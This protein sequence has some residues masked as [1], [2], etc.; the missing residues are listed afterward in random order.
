MPEEQPEVKEEIQKKE[1]AKE[2][3]VEE[4]EEIE[5][6]KVSDDFKID[7][8][9]EPEVIEEVVEE[10]VEE[11]EIDE[12]EV[13]SKIIDKADKKTLDII[14]DEVNIGTGRFNITANDD[15]VSVDV[16]EEVIGV[17][18]DEAEIDDEKSGISKIIKNANKKTLEIIQKQLNTQTIR[19]DGWLD[20]V[21]NKK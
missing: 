1:E 14:Q 21:D 17:I 13:I 10:V 16:N 2:E 11:V 12:I 5:E 7:I 18:L 20:D 8:Q 6:I 3:I 15:G 9:E 19:R 4:F